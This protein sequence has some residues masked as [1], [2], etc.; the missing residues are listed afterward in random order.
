MKIIKDKKDACNSLFATQASKGYVNLL[1]INRYQ[2]CD[3]GC[4]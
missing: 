4:R 2:N 1:L 3:R